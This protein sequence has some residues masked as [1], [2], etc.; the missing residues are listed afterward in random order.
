[1][2]GDEPEA[3]DPDAALNG[4]Q[5]E[6]LITIVKEVAGRAIPRETGLALTTAAFPLDEREAENLLGSVGSPGPAK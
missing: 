2:T 1:M 6:S 3:K 4:A 5:V